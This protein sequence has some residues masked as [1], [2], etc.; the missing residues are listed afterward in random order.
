MKTI[1]FMSFSVNNLTFFNFFVYVLGLSVA[2]MSLF[3]GIIKFLTFPGKQS[4][5]IVVVFFLIF[6]FM[7]IRFL[8]SFIGLIMFP[9]FRILPVPIEL[10]GHEK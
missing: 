7:F 9:L 6:M 4:I 1:E 3:D 5:F 2:L 8:F 10:D